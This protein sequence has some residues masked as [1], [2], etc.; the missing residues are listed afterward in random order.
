MKWSAPAFAVL[1]VFLWGR[2]DATA[3]AE[4]PPHATL[5]ERLD[6]LASDGLTPLCAGCTSPWRVAMRMAMQNDEPLLALRLIR[7]LDG[8]WQGV[9]GFDRPK[10]LLGISANALNQPGQRRVVAAMCRTQRNTR[11]EAGLEALDAELPPAADQPKLP[12]RSVRRSGAMLSWQI[13]SPTFT[14]HRPHPAI[15]PL[16]LLL[17]GTLRLWQSMG[18]KP[19]LDSQLRLTVASPLQGASQRQFWADLGWRGLL[20][21]DDRLLAA[22]GWQMQGPVG[23]ATHVLKQGVPGYEDMVRYTDRMVHAQGG[24]GT[25]AGRHARLDVFAA[26]TQIDALAHQP[27]RWLRSLGARINLTPPGRKTRTPVVSYQ[28][29]RRFDGNRGPW[30]HM[31]TASL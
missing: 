23:A 4:S 28:V 26:A 24:V 27:G 21:S 25:A 8:Q 17:G 6:L 14:K 22:G 11:V 18:A 20:G 30:L 29:A 7:P 12:K 2:Q 15:M 16:G 31:L 9:D 3:K 5:Y 1:L 19:V 13:H 10:W